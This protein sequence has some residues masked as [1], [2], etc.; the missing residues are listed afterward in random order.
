M[1][2]RINN[3]ASASAST[4]PKLTPTKRALIFDHQGCFKC[5]RLYVDHK[6]A[7]CPNNFLPAHTYKPLTAE[8]VE[9]VRDSRNRP[10]PRAP[11]PIAHIG[12]SRADTV[13][14][15]LPSAVLGTGEEESDDSIKYVRTSSLPPF[16]SGHLEWRCR[17]DGPSVPE[18]VVVT[19]LID[20]GSHSVLVDETLVARLGLRKK[21]LPSPQQVRLAMGEEEVVFSEWV[22]LWLYS[23]DQRWTARV[24]RAVVAPK[25][26]YPVILGGP[27]L[28]SNKLV[29]DHEFGRVTAKDD[30][31]QLLPISQ[32]MPAQNKTTAK[33]TAEVK[34]PGLVDVLQELEDRTEG[35]RDRLEEHLTTGP[36]Y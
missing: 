27:F 20:N 29:I 34:I 28:K 18:P 21:Q 26:A 10:R 7:N 35:R 30:Q 32:E 24:V 15:T 22:K 6:G 1:G 14:E 2:T 16:A 5:R 11:A 19:A 33:T 3:T 23:D 13:L 8:Y 25:L 9:A 17:I 31:Y 36:L 4:L 12:Y